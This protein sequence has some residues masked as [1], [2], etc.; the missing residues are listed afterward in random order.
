MLNGV[1]HHRRLHDRHRAV[2]HFERRVI[3]AGTVLRVMLTK[4]DAEYT[5]DFENVFLA[6]D[7]LQVHRELDCETVGCIRRSRKFCLRGLGS[8]CTLRRL[9]SVEQP[10]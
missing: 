10:Q 3:L 7:L 4:A 2:R 6:V 1:E 8:K 5:R 9:R